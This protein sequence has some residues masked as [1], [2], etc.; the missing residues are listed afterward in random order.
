[1]TE[2]EHE[3]DSCHSPSAGVLRTSEYA[4]SREGVTAMLPCATGKVH[5]SCRVAYTSL[6]CALLALSQR[7][8]STSTGIY[9]I[10]C[11]LAV[12]LACRADGG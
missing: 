2:I 11:D 12:L 4:G 8:T 5:C 10:D 3:P 1:M 7:L 6:G 9:K